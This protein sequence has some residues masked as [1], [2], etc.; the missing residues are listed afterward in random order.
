M[1]LLRKDL[2]KVM[3]E[4]ARSFTSHEVSSLIHVEPLA[5]LLLDDPDKG[6]SQICNVYNKGLDEVYTNSK[7][8][9][10]RAFIESIAGGPMETIPYAVYNAVGAVYPYL[11][12]EQKNKALRQV[13]NILD[14]INTRYICESHTN[15]I[16]EPLLLSDINICRWPYWPGLHEGKQIVTK[17]PAFVSFKENMIDSSGRFISGKVLS[18]FIV[19][20]EIL[21]SKN[22]NYGDEYAALAQEKTP[23][24]LERVLKGIAAVIYGPLK[25][26]D[27]AKFDLPARENDGFGNMSYDIRERI[28]K[29]RQEADWVDKTLFP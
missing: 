12:R 25:G 3:E 26:V 23:E 11:N 27:L 19:A 13:L 28:Q 9:N 4:M 14:G 8:E 5:K 17:F 16:R 1:E 2:E 24:F 15:G 10:C 29:Y 6:I 22:C 21:R 20:F 7:G 18:D